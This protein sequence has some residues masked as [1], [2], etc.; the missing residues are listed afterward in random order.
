MWSIWGGMAGII[1]GDIAGNSGGCGF[2]AGGTRARAYIF[3]VSYG[4]DNSEL[5]FQYMLYLGSIIYVYI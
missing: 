3:A 2:D 4:L 5:G 1:A